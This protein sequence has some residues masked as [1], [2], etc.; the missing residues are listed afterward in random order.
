MEKMYLLY[1]WW[2]RMR[3]LTRF[4]LFKLKV[5]KNPIFAVLT[6]TSRCDFRC[7]YCFSDYYKKT[8]KDLSTEKLLQTIDE[9]AQYG[10]I[11]LN[12]HG[13]EALLRKDIGEILERAKKKHM[14]VNL[15]T[16][17]TLL[18]RCWDKVKIIDSFC[19]SLDGREPSNDLNRGA[20]TFKIASEAIDF[21]L[22]KGHTVRIGMTITKYTMDDLEWIAEWAKERNIFIQPFLLF[23][24]ENLPRELWM[25]KGENKRALRKLI[26]LKK[27]GYPIFTA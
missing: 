25:T 6:V 16:N 5:N 12:V 14:F 7:K 20:G 11:Y 3:M 18:K 23:D 4:L 8:E 22:S 2:K 17:G 26:E 27:K 15:I 10:I 9:L 13:G 1:K 21:I 19:V 24:Q